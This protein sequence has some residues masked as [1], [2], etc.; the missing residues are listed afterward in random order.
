MWNKRRRK[1]TNR[2]AEDVLREVTGGPRRL[3]SG[4]VVIPERAPGAP[5]GWLVGSAGWAWRLIVVALAVFLVFWA[6]SRVL[7]AVIAVFLALVITGVLKPIVDFYAKIMPRGAATGLGMLTSLALIGALITFVIQSVTG[8]WSK[9]ASQFQT[10]VDRLYDWVENGPLPVTI[11]R[12]DINGWVQQGLDWL[13]SQAGT[14]A[15]EA[16]QQ[17]TSIAL[18]FMCLALALFCSYFFLAR[19]EEMWRW[20][21]QQLP[22]QSRDTWRLAGGAGWYTFSGYARGTVVLAVIEGILAGLFLWGMGVPLPAPLGVLVFIGGFIPMIGAP[23]AMVIATIVALAA[24]GPVIAAIVCLGIAGIGQ[25][26]GNL[27]HPNIMGKYVSLH[28]VVVAVSVI[29]GTLIGGLFGTVV[30]VPLVACAWSIFLALRPE[31]VPDDT[32]EQEPLADLPDGAVIAA[33]DQ[34]EG[35]NAPTDDD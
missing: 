10:G 2:R 8:Q 19:G 31:P 9:L 35:I 25:I 33:E 20:F 23:A 18:I 32:G 30:S 29:S 7:L 27:L 15:M 14:I 26:E 22:I 21:L 1:E 5:P 34:V 24:N 4:T 12:D 3:P 17:V 13:E 11:T 6:L 16:L 28:P